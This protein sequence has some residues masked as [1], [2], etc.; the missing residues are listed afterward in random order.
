MNWN[1]CLLMVSFP[2]SRVHVGFVEDCLN[3]SRSLTY[4]RTFSRCILFMF[5]TSFGIVAMA[6][7]VLYS[8]LHFSSPVVSDFNLMYHIFSFISSP[9][10]RLSASLVC[11]LWNK[12]M[13]TRTQYLVIKSRSLCSLLMRFSCIKELDASRC[14]DEIILASPFLHGIQTLLIGHPDSPQKKISNVGLRNAASYCSFLHKIVLS[15]LENISDDAIVDITKGCPCL[16]VVSLEDCLNLGDASLKAI[17]KLNN[18]QE[19]TLK[20]KFGFTSEGLGIIGG[21][22][23]SLLKVCLEFCSLE[24]GYAL[25]SISTGCPL[26]QELSLKARTMDPC[27]AWPSVLH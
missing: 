20:G 16:R 2:I 13:I 1:L 11:H 22:C 9:Q 21:D 23:P 7:S 4:M 12:V 27:G 19:I 26:I 25:K 3:L 15:S 8:D 6:E 14:C 10:D 17:C 5:P 24:V 18:M